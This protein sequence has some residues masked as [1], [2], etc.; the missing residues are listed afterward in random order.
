MIGWLYS[1]DVWLFRFI[2]L[3][4][5]NR[6]FDWLMPFV[7]NSPWFACILILI[8]VGLLVKGGPR[9]RLCVL[10]LA[11]SLCLGNWLVTDSLK[12]IVGRLRPFHV[13]ADA[14]LR[15]G[16]GSSFSMPS[17]HAANWFSSMFILMAY[18]RRSVWCM[19]PLALLVGLS[20][21]YNGVH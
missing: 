8:A 3:S 7:S 10:M 4:W 15:I 9:G 14:H 13:I 11:L 19:L 12:H 6:F 18:F 2:N 5:S 17:S 1:V 20:R 16:M 21:I